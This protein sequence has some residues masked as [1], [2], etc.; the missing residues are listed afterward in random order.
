MNFKKYIITVSLVSL[1]FFGSAQAVVTSCSLQSLKDCNRSEIVSIIKALIYAIQTGN[2]QTITP[3][4]ATDTRQVVAN[5]LSKELIEATKKGDSAEVKKLIGRGADVNGKDSWGNTALLEASLAGNLEMVKALIAAGADVNIKAPVGNTPLSLASVRGDIQIVKALIAAGADVRGGGTLF[6][7]SDI[8][9]VKILIAEG[10]EIDA[11]DQNGFTA[12]MWASAGRLD[13][14][15]ELIAAG[16]DVNVKT[17]NGVT[18]LM[19]AH[20]TDI[21]AELKKAGAKE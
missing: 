6:G 16:A 17:K 13:I 8:D 3:S 5:Y 21:I 10:V 18:A 7:V 12:L 19:R 1:F 14:V 20:K 9:V 11:K 15:K 2:H 4:G